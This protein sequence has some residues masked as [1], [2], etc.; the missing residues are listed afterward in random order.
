MKTLT[1][2][3]PSHNGQEQYEIRLQ[4]FLRILHRMPTD[5]EIQSNPQNNNKYLAISYMEMKLDELFFGLWETVDFQYHLTTSEVAGKIDLRVFHPIAK[6][7]ITRSGVAS[8]PL[9]DPNATSGNLRTNFNPT[10]LEKALPH[11]KAECIKNAARSLGKLFG[12]DL[13][14][15]YEDTYKPLLKVR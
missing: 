12:R 6:V 11:L 5:Q 10:P 13:N 8:T 1:Q 14:R 15:D 3:A 7:W 9:Q 2:P 4:Q